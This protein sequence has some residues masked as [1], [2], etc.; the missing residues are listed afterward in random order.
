MKAKRSNPKRIYLISFA[1]I[2]IGFVLIVGFSYHL[3]HTI[4]FAAD[5]VIH[6]KKTSEL[7]YEIRTELIKRSDTTEVSFTSADNIDLAAL[8]VKRAN[9]KANLLLCHGYRGNKELMYSFIDLFPDFNILMFDFRAHGQSSGSI[10]SI[11]YH[12]SKDVLAAAKFLRDQTASASSNPLPFIT[13][14]IS[15]GGAAAVKAAEL[16]PELSDI[17]IVD[18]TYASLPSIGLKGFTQKAHLPQYP[19]YPIVKWMFHYLAQCDISKM[20]PE[21]SVRSITVPIL[22]IHSCDDSYIS[23]KS[24]IRLYANAQNKKSKLWIGPSCRHGRLRNYY[25]ELYKRKITKFLGNTIP[26]I[27]MG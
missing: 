1:T 26:N 8:L 22:F 6:G 12:E 25:T 23:P 21:E 10:T 20:L 4:T 17:I 9:A 24:A 14:G 27:M 2:A 16:N 5:R 13:L 18:S 11:G 7:A 3:L 19:F 15:M